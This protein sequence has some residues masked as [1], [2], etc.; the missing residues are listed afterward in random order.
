MRYLLFISLSTFLLSC[1]VQPED[2]ARV[3][4]NISPDDYVRHPCIVDEQA[5]AE[6]LARGPDYF[7][8][9]RQRAYCRGVTLTP[10]EEAAI[11]L[12]DSRSACVCN[13]MPPI[14]KRRL[15]CSTIP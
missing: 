2:A 14:I 13:Y 4:Q 1:S 12:S 7:Y 10:E 11:R 3:S 8:G 6:C 5:R 9:P 15:E